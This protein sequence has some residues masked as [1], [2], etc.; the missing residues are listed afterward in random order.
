M[1]RWVVTTCVL[2]A[3]PVSSSWAD[4]NDIVLNRLS[5][6]QPNGTFVAQNADLRSLSSQL[7]VVLAPRLGTPADTLGFGGFQFVVDYASTTIDPKAAYWRA[8]EGSPD[9]TGTAGMDHG[10]SSL[11]TIGLF[12]RKGLWFPVPAFEIGAGAVH[13]IDS[14]IW[15]GQFYAKLALHEGYHQWPIPSFAFRAGVS[16]MMQQ[17]SLDLTVVSLDGVVSK[18]FGIGG[19]WRLDPYA[20]YNILLIVPRSEVIDPTPTIDPLVPG[21]EGDSTKN[22]VFKEQDNIVRHRI[23]VGTK[24]QYYVLQLTLEA[25]FAT[26]GSSV[27]DRTGVTDACVPMSSTANCDAKDTAKAQTT[28]SVSAGL[29]F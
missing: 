6:E 5:V 2:A 22:F 19:T 10:P 3:A 14:T 17:R 28:L 18:H 16:R 1:N 15:T 8:R 11:S 4:S 12:A 29:D 9:P 13:L 20:G 25:S 23:V 24:L 7:G 21:N 27:D 26:A